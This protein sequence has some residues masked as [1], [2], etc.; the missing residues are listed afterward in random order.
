MSA[1]EPALDA[2]EE[3]PDPLFHPLHRPSKA[4]WA[5][6]A[7]AT[8]FVVAAAIAY[9]RQLT[10]GLQV[11]GLNQTSQWGIY[12]VNY[13]FWIGVSKGGTLISALLRLTR[14]GWRRRFHR[15]N[16]WTRRAGWT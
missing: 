9:H 16:P 7:V 2:P 6:F 11:T 15:R 13:V 10:Q 4:W 14:S 8:G 3:T 5:G 1:S 12:L